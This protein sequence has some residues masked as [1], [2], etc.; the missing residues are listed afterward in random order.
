MTE[1]E[2]LTVNMPTLECLLGEK[3]TAFAPHTTGV[4]LRKK[5]ELEIAK[6][7]F[8][9]AI[10]SEQMNDQLQ[11]RTTN[12]KAVAEELAFRGL[13]LTREDVLQ[14]TIRACASIIS[15]G[16]YDAEDYAEYMKGIRAISDHILGRRFTPEI[17]AEK[18]CSVMCL[19]ASVLTQTKY[20]KIANPKEYMKAR[21]VGGQYKRLGYIRKRNLGAYSYLVEAT[22][23]LETIWSK[24]VNVL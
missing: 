23:M 3:L 16:A 13:E 15:R 20:P 18:A 8:D 4:P 17:A 14:D 5:K 22:K 7:L 19:A 12:D 2:E 24:N 6:Q 11:F 9:V 21:L 10:L 1:P